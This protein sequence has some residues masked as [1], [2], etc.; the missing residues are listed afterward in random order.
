MIPL[1]PCNEYDCYQVRYKAII[2]KLFP[3]NK[4]EEINQAFKA[5][6]KD[7]DGVDEFDFLDITTAPFKTIKA[8][9]DKLKCCTNNF[10]EKTSKSG[11][12][13]LKD[14]YKEIVGSYNE[15]RK[16]SVNGIKTNILIFKMFEVNVCP[17]CNANYV[18]NRGSKNAGGELDHFY[19]KMTYPIFSVSLYNLIPSCSSCNRPKSKSEITISPHDTDV[20]FD[21]ALKFSYMPKS[22]DFLYNDEQIDIDIR[23]I[24]KDGVSLNENIKKLKIYE[25]YEIH[26]P[27][28]RELITKVIVNSESQI[29]EYLESYPELFKDRNDVL[30]AIF[31]NYISED[32]YGKRPLAKLTKDI[33]SELGVDL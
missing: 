33:L 1:K 28:V 10:K 20:C 25:A 30:R 22:L 26:K 14:V 19:D 18:N 27:Y 17:Y 21:S 9:H 29:D 6:F 4:V 23:V 3:P 31:G 5:D 11:K 32:D 2:E 7:I 16:T 8:L 13:E 24:E 12:P 15:L